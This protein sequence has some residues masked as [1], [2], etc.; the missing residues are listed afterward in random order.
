MNKPKCTCGGSGEE[1][2]I[3]ETIK[4]ARTV[5]EFLWSSMNH[6]AGLEEFRRMFR[7]RVA[8][9]DKVDTKNPHWRIE[10][11]KRLLQTAAIAVN[12]IAKID[13]GTLGHEGVHPTLPSNLSEYSSPTCTAK[14]DEYVKYAPTMTHSQIVELLR[15]RDKLQETLTAAQGEVERLRV[16]S[17]KIQKDEIKQPVYPPKRD[18]AILG[19]TLH[20]SL[21]WTDPK[22]AF[23]YGWDRAILECSELLAEAEDTP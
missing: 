15:F 14:E 3:A 10:V 11:K 4:A 13:S 20:D 8:K 18:E 19:G 12:M 23:I 7:K 6:A 22:I 9:L 21:D 5:Q 17:L 16:A 2:I 1:Q